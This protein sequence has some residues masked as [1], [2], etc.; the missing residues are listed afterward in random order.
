M[1]FSRILHG[2]NNE[3]YVEFIKY[4]LNFPLEEEFDAYDCEIVNV[5]KGR[6]NETNKVLLKF[7]SLDEERIVLFCFKPY[8]YEVIEC[9][10]SFDMKIK[11]YKVENEEE[12]FEHRKKYFEF[13]SEY[14]LK[15]GGA[16]DQEKY[17][18]RA[19][20]IIEKYEEQN[21]LEN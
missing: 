7:L 11:K 5:V 17:N 20:A 8:D 14:I 21:S 13:I 2:I 19:N 16:L 12:H 18:K 1:D 6:Q 10:V 3:K 4:S 15:I 9:S